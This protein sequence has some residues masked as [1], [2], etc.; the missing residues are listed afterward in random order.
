[1]TYKKLSMAATDDDLLA[2][3]EDMWDC[4]G[5]PPPEVQ[6]LMQIISLRNLMK[7]LMAEKMEYDGRNMIL[8]VH[9]SSPID[10][11]R[12]IELARKKWKGMR[13]T[14]DHRLFIP[15]PDLTEGQVIEAAKGLLEELSRN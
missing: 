9:K 13:I 12:L 2:M 14:P 15:M 6:N 4:Y 7:G 10:P 5:P 11:M 3:K 1:V 8:A